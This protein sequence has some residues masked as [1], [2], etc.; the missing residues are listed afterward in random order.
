MSDEQ[1][2]LYAVTHDDLISDDLLK[3][4][5]YTSLVLF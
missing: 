3:V 5:L 2:E 4:P 1:P